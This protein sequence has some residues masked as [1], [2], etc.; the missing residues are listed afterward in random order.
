MSVHH[1]CVPVG[2]HTNVPN[3]SSK[4]SSEGIQHTVQRMNKWKVFFFFF[5]GGGGGGQSEVVQGVTSDQH[6][7]VLGG[8]M[9]FV[10]GGSQKK[11]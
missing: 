2:P 5:G 9:L 11:V 3:C 6:V 4:L 1:L 7:C 10:Q 8:F